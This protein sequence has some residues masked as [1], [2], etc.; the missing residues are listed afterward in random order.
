MGRST[1]V[2]TTDEEKFGLPCPEPGRTG[3]DLFG[4]IEDQARSGSSV[5]LFKI[6]QTN[7][8]DT[9]MTVSITQ[10]LSHVHMLNLIVENRLI[11]K[12][13]SW[14]YL[15]EIIRHHGRAPRQL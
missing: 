6:A 11:F 2:E 13:I 14:I 3:R 4:L 1:N 8:V 9:I 10:R 5:R 15:E 7:V 12:L